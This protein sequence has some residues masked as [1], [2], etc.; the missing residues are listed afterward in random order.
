MTLVS[1]APDPSATLLSK[2]VA[3]ISIHLCLTAMALTCST[4]VSWPRP[5]TGALSQPVAKERNLRFC[6]DRHREGV[7]VCC[8]QAE[9]S[10]D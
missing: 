2:T 9:V 1:Q 10:S 8:Q 5:P 6:S 4:S 7:R 3:L